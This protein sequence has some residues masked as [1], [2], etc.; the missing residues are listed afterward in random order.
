MICMLL[1]NFV[2]YVFLLLCMFYVFCF[3]VLFCV[4]FVC[5]CV[6]YCC[7]RVSTQLHLTNI[8][9]HR[10]IYLT[11]TIWR[12]KPRF[13]HVHAY[14][15]GNRH[16]PDL[17]SANTSRSLFY[18]LLWQSRTLR[19][20]RLWITPFILMVFLTLTVFFFFVS[21]RIKDQLDVTCYFISLLM[22]STCFGH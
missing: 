11:T 15:I 16:V 18:L 17:G 8:S 5:K 4:L 21:W 19:S 10:I 2:N 22:C 13:H 1:F 7:H 20:C 14:I 9:Y 6:L 3:I 12:D